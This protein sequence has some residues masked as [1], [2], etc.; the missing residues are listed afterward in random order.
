MKK[1]K[2]RDFVARMLRMSAR[3]GTPSQR[4]YK[5]HHNQM[6]LSLKSRIAR[7]LPDVLPPLLGLMLSACAVGPDYRQP[8]LPLPQAWQAALPHGGKEDRLIDWWA[9]FNDPVLTQ[10]LRTAEQDSPTLE[11]SAAV[12][13]QSRAALTNSRAGAFPSLTGRASSTRATAT[14]PLDGTQTTTG[15]AVDAAWELDLFGSVRRATEGA[16]ARLQGTERDWH[17]AR[18]SLAAEVATNYASYRACQQLVAANG[19]EAQ[20]RRETAKLVSTMVNAGFTAPAD[21]YLATAGAATAAAN[22]TAQQAQCDLTIKSLVALTGMEEP[23]LRS[24]LGADATLP[25]PAEFSI[26]SLP[27]ALI[28]QRPD[29]ASAESALAAANADVGVA[30]ASRYPRLSLNGSISFGVVNVAGK[31]TEATS[32][33]FGPAL[34]VPLFD[35][36]KRRADVRGA[37]ARYAQALANYKLAV[38]SAVKEVEQALVNL[39]SAARRETDA[40]AAAESAQRYYR[41]VEA[42]WRSGGANLITLED[43]RRTANNA[44]LSLIG[45]QRDRVLNWISLYKALGGDWQQH[46]PIEKAEAVN[47]EKL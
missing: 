44:E 12:I 35:A 33:S 19:R 41:A 26:A 16:R 46:A 7:R 23:V 34:T 40:R 1:C 38:R 18:V 3:S 17:Q 5:Q 8:E 20:S 24:Q 25:V 11:K 4:L 43:A 39:D 27:V 37:Q 47:G 28:S 14:P 15:V 42:N 21:G 45:L 29:L 30:E 22:L 9:Q 32:W 6:L 36:G 2:V 31:S 13:E 10:L